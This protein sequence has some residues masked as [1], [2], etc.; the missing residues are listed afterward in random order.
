MR[1]IYLNAGT[2]VHFAHTASNDEEPVFAEGMAIIVE[3]NSIKSIQNSLTLADE[4]SIPSD[5]SHFQH[6][7]VHVHD[8]QGQAIVPGLP[9]ILVIG[10]AA[11]AANFVTQSE[12]LE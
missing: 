12:H 6:E 8:L 9:C 5:V 3:G 4:Y 10:K 1:T 11:L 7:D 2:M